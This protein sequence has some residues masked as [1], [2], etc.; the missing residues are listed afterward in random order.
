MESKG[1]KTTENITPTSAK[2]FQKEREKREGGT[3][4]T[5]PSKL[6]VRAKKPDIQTLVKSEVF[7]ADLVNLLMRFQNLGAVN[8]RNLDEAKKMIELQETIVKES[9]M[10]PK[11]VDEPNDENKGIAI[12][13][14]SMDDKV[15]IFNWATGG[16]QEVQSF[17]NEGQRSSKNAKPD[18]PD[19][20]QQ[21][22]K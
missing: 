15:F 11:I 20:S 17:R 9:V 8:I 5:L 14:L 16:A 22:A 21:E 1:Q 2:E 4:L 7:P 10:E 6:K 12:T 18:M 19:I 13:D 3:V